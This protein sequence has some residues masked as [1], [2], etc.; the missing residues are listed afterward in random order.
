MQLLTVPFFHLPVLRTKCPRQHPAL[1]LSNLSLPLP[2]H[3]ET[4]CN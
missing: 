2:L 3:S 1:K 4:K